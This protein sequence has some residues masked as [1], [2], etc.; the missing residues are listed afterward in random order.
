MPN[1]PSRPHLLKVPPS[2]NSSTLG[3]KPLMH[4]PLED[5]RSTLQQEPIGRNRSQTLV[6]AV[7]GTYTDSLFEPMN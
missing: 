6:P 4:R 5:T 2:S 3:N 1:L 7:T